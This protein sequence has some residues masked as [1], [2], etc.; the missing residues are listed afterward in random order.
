MS[1]ELVVATALD[2]FIV[3]QLANHERVPVVDFRS[4]DGSPPPFPFTHAP[5]LFR[6]LRAIA[7]R[8]QE[9][10]AALDDDARR[11]RARHLSLIHI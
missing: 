2:R 6:K 3:W 11:A 1:D 4:L 10:V 9:A 8:T 7:H 5:L